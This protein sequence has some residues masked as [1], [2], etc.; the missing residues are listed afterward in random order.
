M[1]LIRPIPSAS[2][3][4]TFSSPIAL[5]YTASFD[6]QTIGTLTNAKGYVT[7][8]DANF[9]TTSYPNSKFNVYVDGTLR[10]SYS[11][12]EVTSASGTFAEI[13]DNNLHTIELKVINTASSGSSLTGKAISI[14]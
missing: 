4:I 13:F 5:T 2:T 11:A 9:Y 1:A 7:M 8:F 12:T 6:E 10:H 3:D 14:S